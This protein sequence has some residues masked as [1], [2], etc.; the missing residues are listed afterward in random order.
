[1][2]RYYLTC[3]NR[4]EAEELAEAKAVELCGEHVKTAPARPE[5]YTLSSGHGLYIEEDKKA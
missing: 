3:G 1:M 2:R 5:P 4:A